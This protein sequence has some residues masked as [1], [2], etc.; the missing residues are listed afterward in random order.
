MATVTVWEKIGDDPAIERE[1][2]LSEE[3]TGPIE[4]AEEY[5]EWA[6]TNASRQVFY[7]YNPD[8]P[9]GSP[10]WNKQ[11]S[12]CDRPA[13]ASD[14]GNRADEAQERERRK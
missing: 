8:N 7:P 14:G 10:Q 12:C 13:A 1:F 3:I 6:N 5:C 2:Q 4:T 11:Q 9:R